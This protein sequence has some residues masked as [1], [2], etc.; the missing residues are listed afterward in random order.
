MSP[1][2]PAMVYVR[3]ITPSD[4][5][6]VSLSF[7]LSAAMSVCS[8]VSWQWRLSVLCLCPSVRLPLCLSTAQS[9]SPSAVVVAYSFFC[10]QWCMFV[11]LSIV[12]NVCLFPCL[13]VAVSAYLSLCLSR[14]ESVKSSACLSLCF[15]VQMVICLFISLLFCRL[16]K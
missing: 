6:G 10:Q 7:S 5:R 2:L 4:S 9:A 14:A 1:S 8:P 13:L 11:P 16:L 15:L 3:S 12:S